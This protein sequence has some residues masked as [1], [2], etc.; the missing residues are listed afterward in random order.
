M[1]IK[2]EKLK[3]E[4]SNKYNNI[5]KLEDKIT[6]LNNIKKILFE[7]S[8][9]KH[10]PVDC[11]IWVKISQLYANDYNPNS[12][13]NREMKLLHKSVA[14]D[15]YTMPIVTI[16][17]KELKKYEIVD[18]FHRFSIPRYYEDIAKKNF[19]YLPITFIDK[20]I[21]DKMASTIRH[22]RARGKHSINGMSNIVFNMLDNGWT[23]SRIC[24]E[25]G[26][27]AEELIK[28]KHITGFS[29]LFENT[30]YKKAWE[31]KKQ[32]LLRKKWREE[33]N[34]TGYTS[35]I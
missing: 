14:E 8:P 28:L 27:E 35:S 4:I 13:A 25:L 32:V 12:V 3:E 5:E 10:N 20:D 30:E 19:N 9:L 26:M 11:P 18:G 6:F 21:N 22:N 31:T 23:D 15:G 1:V 16:Y 29:K 33:N 17:N 24:D 2:M 7:L 34:D